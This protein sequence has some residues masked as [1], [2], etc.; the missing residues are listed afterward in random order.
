MSGSVLAWYVA[1]N[2]A[3]LLDSYSRAIS[4]DRLI[5]CLWEVQEL[6]GLLDA[7]V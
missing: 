3:N 6:T 1:C 5:F 4:V 2:T 7:G